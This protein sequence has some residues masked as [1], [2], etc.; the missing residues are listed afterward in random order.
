MPP[1]NERDRVRLSFTSL[2]LG[3]REFSTICDLYAKNDSW[4]ET[5]QMVREDNL[6]QRP[7]AKTAQRIFGEIRKRIETLSQETIQTFSDANSEDRIAIAYLAACKLYPIIFD[8]VRF[9]LLEKIAVFDFS[10]TENDFNA[11]WNRIIIDHPD[12][13]TV[14]EKTQEK[15][16]QNVFKMLGEAGIISNRSPFDLTVS[17]LS[18][19]LE[20]LLDR[21]GPEYRQAFLIQ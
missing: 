16:R 17:P 2:A 21:E 20:N 6:L 19:T 8:F 15:A 11:Y 1:E 14:T 5:L 18:T 3:F 12:L 9:T 10:A 4:D 7:S 13:E